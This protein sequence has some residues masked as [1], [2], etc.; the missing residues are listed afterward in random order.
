MTPDP[1]K[2]SVVI[3]TYNRAE[4]LRRTLRSLDG[5][6]I[7]DGWEIIVVDN[8]STDDTAAIIG[9]AAA[10]S[11]MPIRYVHEIGRAHV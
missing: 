10:T 7:A 3:A 4:E 5:V 8:N 11:S 6:R 9:E 1:I 2:Y